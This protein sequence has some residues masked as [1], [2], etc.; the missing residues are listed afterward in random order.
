MAYQRANTDWMASCVFGISVHWTAQTAP[1]EGSACS[2][3]DA[4]TRFRLHEFLDAVRLSGADY[5]IFTATHALQ[6][7]PCP[8][9]I[10]DSILPGR[11]T[12]RDLLGELA[13]EL[14]AIGK[15][16]I[17]YYNHSCNRG[18]DPAWERAVGYHDPSKDRLAENLCGI[19]KWMGERYGRLIR[20]WWFD[21]SYSLDPR[22]TRNSVTTDMKGF[23]FPWERL[24]VAAKSGDAGRLVAYNA[25]VGQ[26][27]LYTEH[28]D[29]WAG[30]LTDLN[31]PPAGRFLDSGLQWH[32]WTCLDDQRWVYKDNRREPHPPLYSDGA[33]LTFL[34]ACRRHQAPMCFNV[35]VFQDGSMAE[36]SILQLNRIGRALTRNAEPTGPGDARQH[37]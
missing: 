34:S 22:G 21:S 5:V 24:T 31:T 17:V 30:E 3:A 36:A 26:T 15:K 32:G 35:V 27:F 14:E 13:R 1:R 10:V 6:M 18:D 7:L 9:P 20:A 28:Q 23:Q 4:V 8:H 16:L 2:F 19:V 11:T 37:A 25:G 33:L 29:Y 12:E